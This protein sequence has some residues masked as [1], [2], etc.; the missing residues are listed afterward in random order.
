MAALSD[1][2]VV[3][4]V[5]G[6]GQR[7]GRSRKP[8]S[9]R[10]TACCSSI[11]AS[12]IATPEK[13]L[14]LIGRVQP[15]VITLD[16]VSAIWRPRLEQISAMYPYS[17]SFAPVPRRSGGVAIL[18]RR[19]FA[20]GDAG[21]CL[22][23]RRLGH[24]ADR[25]R[26]TGGR[27][28]GAASRLAVAVQAAM[29]ARAHCASRWQRL[30]IRHCLPAISTPRHGAPPCGA[31]EAA[32]GLGARRRDG[33]TWLHRRLPDVLRPFAGLPIDQVFAKG[34]IVILRQRRWKTSAPTILP[35]L[36]E[37][38]LLGGAAPEE[39]QRRRRH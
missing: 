16:E 3:V 15:D 12:T 5:S 11:C 35:V 9:A 27:R 14:S 24:R 18:S 2:A 20:A 26:R 36:V 33:P 34:D 6:P 21:R 4:S 31:I 29:A 17:R 22:D 13:V 25:F 23:R 10:S 37:F 1:D 19:P 30:A 28:R 38:S 8:A 32:A 7:R 39:M